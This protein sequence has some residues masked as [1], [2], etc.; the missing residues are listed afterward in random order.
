[1]AA[2]NCGP[3]CVDKAVQRTGYADFWKLRDLGALPRE[4]ANYVPLILAMTIMG[5]NAKDYGL[6]DVDP[7][8]TLEYET[9]KLEAPTSLSLLADAAE[10]SVTEIRELNPSVLKSV[11]PAGYELRLPK[12]SAG[13]VTAAFESIPANR[14]ATWR[15]HRVAAGETLAS[16]AQ[17]YRTAASAIAEANPE[18]MDGPSAGEVLIIPASYNQDQKP[19][20]QKSRFKKGRAAVA[21]HSSKRGGTRMAASSRSRGHVSAAS[22]QRRASTPRVKAAGLRRVSSR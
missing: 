21:S 7:E 11:A 18:A 6:D 15:M 16:I 1:M 19:A 3:G 20:V 5:K 12:G 10:R 14:R 13:A 17:R 9:I 8:P 4:T 2:Y 22:L